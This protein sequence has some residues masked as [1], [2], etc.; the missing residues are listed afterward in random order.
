MTKYRWFFLL[1]GA[2]AGADQLS[3]ALIASIHP[4]YPIEII[5]HW[6]YLIKTYNTGAAW[7]LFEGRSFILGLLGGGVLYGI[8]YFRRDLELEIPFSQLSLG[9][10]GGGVLGNMIDRLRSG[11]VL[12]FIQVYLGSYPWP[13]F[14]VAD[15]AIVTGVGLYSLSVW[16]HRK[17]EG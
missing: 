15:M 6:L 11:S 9:L 4:F 12:D 7:S 10:F 8:W 13:T 1:I 17:G 5:Q 16:R 14:N 2:V 3:K